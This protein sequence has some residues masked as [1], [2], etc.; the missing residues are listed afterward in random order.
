[1]YCFR[2]KYTNGYY[3]VARL[4]FYRVNSHGELE[5]I[6]DTTKFLA[7]TEMEIHQ[8]GAFVVKK[9]NSTDIHDDDAL[10][11]FIKEESNKIE[12]IGKAIHYLMKFLQLIYRTSAKVII[13]DLCSK[14]TER[15]FQNMEYSPYV[16]E[17]LQGN[18]F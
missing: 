4:E 8:Y 13:Y 16:C 18:H 15:E 17:I 14:H 10:S 9:F 1:M 12:Q 7:K 2:V 11:A 3:S 5:Y 6:T